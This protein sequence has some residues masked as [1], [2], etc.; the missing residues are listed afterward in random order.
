MYEIYKNSPMY[1][2][3]LVA[4]I[5]KIVT[6]ENTDLKSARKHLATSL[7]NVSAKN[8]TKMCIEKRIKAY[9][10]EKNKH[11]ISSLEK[12]ELEQK[13]ASEESCLQQMQSHITDAENRRDFWD[14]QV[15]NLENQAR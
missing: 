4:F 11:G 14:N 7:S 12:N 13:I 5:S 2:F 8:Y 15:R 10:A 3:Q 1:F 6:S 9:Q